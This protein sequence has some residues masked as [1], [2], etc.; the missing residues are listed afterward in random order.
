MLLLV[1]QACILAFVF[2]VVFEP[3]FTTT[4][5][6]GSHRD[7]WYVFGLFILFWILAFGLRSMF[8]M[9]FRAGLVAVLTASW[10]ALS[11]LFATW[12]ASVVRHALATTPLSALDTVSL[13][14]Q[15]QLF[16]RVIRVVDR[17]VI[18]GTPR[19]QRFLFIPKE[20][21]SR[22]DFATQ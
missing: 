21:V 1:L 12:Q 5:R 6:I 9:A 2:F 16:G 20:K 18:I 19:P 8:F 22:I 10:L 3:F 13:S 11:V 7:R 14:D 4:P 15:G 17:G